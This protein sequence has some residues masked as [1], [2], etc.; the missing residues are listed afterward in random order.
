MRRLAAAVLV[1]L[2]VA[3]CGSA[4]GGAEEGLDEVVEKAEDVQTGEG[5]ISATACEVE[6][7]VIRTAVV[8]HRAT[9]G[10][11]D[12][13]PTVDDLVAAGLLDQAPTP[14]WR[15]TYAADGTPTVAAD[16]GSR[17]A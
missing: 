8:A 11:P 5:P 10:D 3:A 17:C 15:I 4:D 6:Q 12:A 13:R 2:L 14:G 7:R 1:A 16:P 9:V